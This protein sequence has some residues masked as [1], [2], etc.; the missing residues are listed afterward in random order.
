MYIKA[1]WQTHV[2]ANIRQIV[3]TVLVH[4]TISSID[5]LIDCLVGPP[6]HHVASPVK[7]SSAVIKAVRQFVPQYCA[8][9]TVIQG[10][11]KNAFG[12]LS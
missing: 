2:F 12:Q 10:S 6:L 9:R 1:A 7:A 11:N 4:K 3:V 8:N 5:V